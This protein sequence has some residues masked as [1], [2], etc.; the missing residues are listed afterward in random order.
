MREVEGGGAPVEVAAELV[1]QEGL[2]AAREADQDD[3]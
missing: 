2:P 3:D 1:A